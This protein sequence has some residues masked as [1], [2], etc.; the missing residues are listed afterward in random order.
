MTALTQPRAFSVRGKPMYGSIWARASIRF[1][2]VLPIFALP[3]TWAL[4]CASQ[5]PSALTM[6]KVKSS[7]VFRSRPLRV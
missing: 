5:P 4:T 3:C 6:E 1:C 7:R 2:L